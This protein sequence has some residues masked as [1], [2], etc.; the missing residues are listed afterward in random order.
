V[1]LVHKV[2]LVH[3]VLHQVLLDHRVHKVSLVLKDHKVQQA[4]KVHKVH[5]VQQVQ[6]VH[7]DHRVLLVQQVL[8]ELAQAILDLLAMNLLVMA[9][10]LI[11]F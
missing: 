4:H 6:Q 1:I 3:K 2:H 10:Q 11:S 7:K 8:A 5:K 9:I